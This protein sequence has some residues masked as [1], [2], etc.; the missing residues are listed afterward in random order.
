MTPHFL[1]FRA[2]FC[3]AQFFQGEVGETREE[4]GGQLLMY[5]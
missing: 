3:P 2:A 5:S 4:A 1:L